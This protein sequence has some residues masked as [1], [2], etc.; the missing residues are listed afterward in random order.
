MHNVYFAR[1]CFTQS[2]QKVQPYHDHGFD[3]ALGIDET[4][5]SCGVALWQCDIEMVIAGQVT[6]GQEKGLV[7]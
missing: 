5:N 6:T 3:I 1:R 4:V 7:P 2:G